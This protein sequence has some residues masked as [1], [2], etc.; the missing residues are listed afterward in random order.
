VERDV[1]AINGTAFL[2]SLPE[3]EE[4]FSGLFDRSDE[5]AK[6]MEEIAGCRADLDNALLTARQVRKL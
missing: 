5:Y 2:L 3:R 4:R 6:L 1:L